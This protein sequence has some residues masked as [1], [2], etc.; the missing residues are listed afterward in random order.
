M[1]GS[2]SFLSLSSATLRL[3]PAVVTA[4]VEVLVLLVILRRTSGGSKREL[5]GV[6]MA[7]PVIFFLVDDFFGALED[8]DVAVFLID[9]GVCLI[10]DF[11]SSAELDRFLRFFSTEDGL[12]VRV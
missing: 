5:D 8:S 12:A 3:G 9:L 2:S 6:A 4:L 10:G 11:S 1:S 7:G